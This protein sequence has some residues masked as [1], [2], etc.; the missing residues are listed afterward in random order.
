MIGQSDNIGR[1]HDHTITNCIHNT[2]ATPKEK[3]GS[4]GG[5]NVQDTEWQPEIQKHNTIPH[6][7]FSIPMVLTNSLKN[8]RTKLINFWNSS[9]DSVNSVDSG[10]APSD[11]LATLMIKDESKK[12]D[13]FE[14]DEIE[15]KVANVEGAVSGGLR[16]EQGNIKK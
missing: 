4:S 11:T 5:G 13:G 3:G 12:I 9:P 14:E 1:T 7:V 15:R 8:I 6:N 2:Q 10:K 16:K